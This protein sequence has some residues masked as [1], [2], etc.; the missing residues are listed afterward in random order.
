[1]LLF[2]LVLE[3]EF[4]EFVLKQN[5][6]KKSTDSFD[7]DV[8]NLNFETQR[9]YF[10]PSFDRKF[11]ISGLTLRNKQFKQEI[12]LLQYCDHKLKFDNKAFEATANFNITTSQIYF[13][14]GFSW[15]PLCP[16]NG[17]SIKELV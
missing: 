17:F 9:G 8:Y 15:D 10:T 14:K 12:H 13:F 1:M 7:N 6:L 2:P 3:P 16:I 4:P 5:T 11:N